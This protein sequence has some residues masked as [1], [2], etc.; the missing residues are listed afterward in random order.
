MFKH[1]IAFFLFSFAIGKAF[2]GEIWLCSEAH[3]G[4]L[5]KASQSVPGDSCRLLS[6]QEALMQLEELTPPPKLSIREGKLFCKSRAKVECTPTSDE[7]E[8]GV[9]SGI[10]YL[11]RR[12]YA[13]V[14]AWTVN[15]KRDKMTDKR[16]CLA[17]YND[18]Y[19]VLR[20]GREF[21]S[22]G[23][24]HYPGSATSI[25]LGAKRYDTVE[26]DGDF[27]QNLVPVLKNGTKTVTRFMKWPYRSWVDD[28]FTL[29]GVEETL[30]IGR[31]MLRNAQLD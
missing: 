7:E 27:S 22:I 10:D 23:T 16:Q 18:L 14:G 8:R 28:E 31:W 1:L 11:I 29:Y 6:E 24:D 26:R 4:H 13:T 12:S 20:P 25:K 2:A 17:N 19:I 9:V 21:V 3:D 5:Y 30:A 15:C